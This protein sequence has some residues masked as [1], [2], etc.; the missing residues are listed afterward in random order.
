VKGPVFL[1]RVNYQSTGVT[2]MKSANPK[3]IRHHLLIAGLENS[4]SEIMEQKVQHPALNIIRTLTSILFIGGLT[5]LFIF[6]R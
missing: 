1:K 2:S 6:H 3:K 4:N 5:Y